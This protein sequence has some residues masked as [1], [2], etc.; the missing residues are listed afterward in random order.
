MGSAYRKR[1][2]RRRGAIRLRPGASP[3]STRCG[4][5]PGEH[6]GPDGDGL[7]VIKLALCHK[8]GRQQA[9]D[10]QASVAGTGI[11]VG[12]GHRGCGA[13]AVNAWCHRRGVFAGCGGS[14]WQGLSGVCVAVAARVLT[15]CA[16][17]EERLRQAPLQWAARSRRR[18][19]RV[20]TVIRVPQERFGIASAFFG[21][22]VEPSRR[23]SWI[24]QADEARQ[25]E[26]RGLVAM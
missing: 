19:H 4:A 2:R 21:Q 10:S 7:D 25:P 18:R 8:T 24:I 14:Y 9:S 3:A 11:I 22:F 16:R 26:V 15:R 20:F 17:P 13:V 5:P 6:A 23:R 1:Q 12:A